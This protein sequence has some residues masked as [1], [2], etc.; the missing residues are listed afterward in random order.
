MEKENTKVDLKNSK[1]NKSQ[2]K[3]EI[4]NLQKGNL[5]KYFKSETM[6]VFM[7]HMKF[8]NSFALLI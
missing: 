6:K 7:N 5:L 4:K 8:A 1:K 2:E 3:K